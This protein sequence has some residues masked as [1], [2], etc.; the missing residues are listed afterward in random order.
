MLS[1]AQN[2][3]LFAIFFSIVAAA[4]TDKCPC[5]YLSA[6]KVYTDL[7]ETDFTTVKNLLGPSSGWQ[8]QEYTIPAHPEDDKPF[9][10]ETSRD[11]IILTNDGVQLV[12]RPAKDGVIS[13]S[14]LVTPRTDIRYGSFRVGMKG[15]SVGGT[16]A[17]F[18]WVSV[19]EH[20]L[21][22]EER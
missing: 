4:N 18:F 3:L 13:G 20:V 6:G 15:S 16:C 22:S 2:S 11:N 19:L 8:L 7:Q 21:H 1:F 9:A 10:R 12:V 17:A 14:E 5:G